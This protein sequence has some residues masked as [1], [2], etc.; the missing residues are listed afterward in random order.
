MTREV[1]I[2]LLLIIT[3]FSASLFFFKL[4]LFFDLALDR[5]NLLLEFVLVNV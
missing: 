4:I 3:E 5:V 1:F 2:L